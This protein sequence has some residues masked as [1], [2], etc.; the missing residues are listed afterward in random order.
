MGC[1]D[2]PSERDPDFRGDSAEKPQPAKPSEPAR[3]DVAESELEA[4]LRSPLA[5]LPENE[6]KG[7]L[8]EINPDLLKPDDMEPDLNA[9]LSQENDMRVTWLAIVLGFLIFF[10]PGLAILW[11]SKRIPIKTKVVTS[12]VA[13][14]LATCVVIALLVHG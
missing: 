11:I 6:P 12:I 5:R 8:G 9:G 14:A 13:S 1:S 2:V 7:W 10:V 3:E 4:A